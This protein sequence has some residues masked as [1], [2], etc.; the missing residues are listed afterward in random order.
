MRLLNT[1]YYDGKLVENYK[2]ILDTSPEREAKIISF[3]QLKDDL[4]VHSPKQF[5]SR[6]VRVV[7]LIQSSIGNGPNFDRT[8]DVY[9]D[10]ILYQIC[11]RRT[12]DLLPLLAEQLNDILASGSCPQ[13]RCTR[14]FQILRLLQEK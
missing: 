7:D 2:M 11:Q 12:I 8:N 3:K 10:D 6:A 4:I 9:A 13:G 5:V 1:H 14:L